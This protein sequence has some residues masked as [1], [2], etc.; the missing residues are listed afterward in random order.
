ML[1][2]IKKPSQTCYQAKF[3]KVGGKKFPLKFGPVDHLSRDFYFLLNAIFYKLSYI[4]I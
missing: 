4:S 2:D 1:I 3:E